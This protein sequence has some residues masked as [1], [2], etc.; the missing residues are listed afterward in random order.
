MPLHHTRDFR[1]HHDKPIYF[2]RS[3]MLHNKALR[4]MGVHSLFGLSSKTCA[5]SRMNFQ[6][7]LA[8]SNVPPSHGKRFRNAF[9]RRPVRGSHNLAEVL[10]I[11][12]SFQSGGVL[13]GRR[14][15]SAAEKPKEKN[16]LRH[17][18]LAQKF[19]SMFTIHLRL[20]T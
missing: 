9:G 2:V 6:T 16:S 10:L 18:F 3:V 19:G 7:A 20:G 8:W 17:I 13:C 15:A 1:R 5:W 12:Y 4:V 11:G 14:Q